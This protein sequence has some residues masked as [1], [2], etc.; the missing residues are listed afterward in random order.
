M[1]AMQRLT[2]RTLLLLL[3]A[4]SSTMLHAQ[5]LSVDEIKQSDEYLWGEGQGETNT[6]AENRALK[7]L[8]SKISI[9][10]ETQFQ[11]I[12]EEVYD[13]DGELDSRAACKSVI[14]TYSQATL[15]NTQSVIVSNEPDAHIFRYVRRDD[16]EKIFEGRKRLVH[17]MVES[18][19]K[20]EARGKIDNALQN[21]YSAFCLLQSIPNANLVTDTEGHVLMHQIPERINEIFDEIEFYEGT[22]DGFLA[23]IQVLYKGMPVTTM[24][25]TYFDGMEWSQIVRVK[26]GRGAVELRPGIMLENLQFKCEYEFRNE[27]HINKEIAKVRELMKGTSFPNAYFKVNRSK[28]QD[29]QPTLAMLTTNNDVA[30]AT[31]EIH[32]NT[33]EWLSD[34]EEEPFRNVIKAVINAIHCKDYVAA[35]HFFTEDG[36]DMYRRLISYGSARVLGNPEYRFYA[37]GTGEITCRSIPMHF[38][39]KNNNQKFIEDVTFTFNQEGKIDCLAFA[40]D[41]KSMVDILKHDA[42]SEYARKVLAEFLENYKTAYALKRLDYIRS[43]FDDNAV[44]ITGKV[45]TRHSTTLGEINNEYANNRNVVYTRQNKEQY[46][47]NLERCFESNEFVNI[48]FAN[49]DIVR[50]NNESAGEVYGIQ[51]KQDYYSANYGDTGYLFLMVD[52]NNPKKP[53]INARAWQPE[54]D[55]T[56][57]EDGL[58]DL[59]DF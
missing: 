11:N 32:N 7:N 43:I 53:I 24:A 14:N 57:G 30:T 20:A 54:R 3:W 8:I 23:G 18:A 25:Y 26:D 19:D 44:I 59:A 5:S 4:V 2:T 40:L 55:P 10:V 1:R 37:M 15:T 56:F 46:M 36:K 33:I 13:E 41:E 31:D 28:K 22:T 12:E 47:R 9:S 39:F 34:K 17:D 50:T 58:I 52:L 35:E 51:I 21:Y 27:A 48:R 38:S 45:L 49:N 29:S 16:V 42:W 6:V